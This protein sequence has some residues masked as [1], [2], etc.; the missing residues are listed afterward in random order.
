M[1]YKILYLL[2]ETIILLEKTWRILRAHLVEG[3][4]LPENIKD[5]F[6]D[7]KKYSHEVNR[8]LDRFIQPK[9]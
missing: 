3:K 1:E 4:P 9:E 8:E 7:V 2:S 5:L 6:N